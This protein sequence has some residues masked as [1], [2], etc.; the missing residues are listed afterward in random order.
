VEKPFGVELSEAPDDGRAGRVKSLRGTLAF[1]A[2]AAGIPAVTRRE[3]PSS[4][5]VPATGDP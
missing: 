2:D 4:R 3:G 1:D 5:A